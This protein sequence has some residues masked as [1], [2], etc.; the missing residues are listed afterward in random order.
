LT[1]H[2]YQIDTRNSLSL[3]L[4]NMGNSSSADSAGTI[5]TCYNIGDHVRHG[6][7]YKAAKTTVVDGAKG[8]ALDFASGGAAS[9]YD[10]ASLG[11][12]AYTDLNRTEYQG[13]GRPRNS[14]RNSNGYHD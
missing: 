11:R 5:G 1:K 9:A 2:H 12:T 7:Y 13:R 10:V 14:D 6:N 3:S 4:F 8:I